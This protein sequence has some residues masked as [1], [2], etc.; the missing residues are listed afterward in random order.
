MNDGKRSLNLFFSKNKE[1]IESN[2]NCK[3]C[4][5]NVETVKIS[6]DKFLTQEFL[7]KKL[8]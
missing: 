2:T 5:S 7:K 8:S 6:E 3:I 4:V 1:I